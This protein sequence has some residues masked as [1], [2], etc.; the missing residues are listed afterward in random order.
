VP[1]SARLIVCGWDEVFILDPDRPQKGK[2]WSWRAADRPELPAQAAALFATTDECKPVSRGRL[3]IASSG[4]AVALVRRSTGEVLWW[5]ALPN[6]HSAEMLPGGRIVAA[7]STATHGGNRFVLYDPAFGQRELDSAPAVAAHG[8]VWD[9]ERQTLWGLCF[10]ELHA[11]GL[12]DWKGAAP[13]LSIRAAIDLPDD[14]GHDLA[15]MPGSSFLALSTRG[16]CWVFDRD[17]LRF[18]A[19]P[20]LADVPHVK[21]MDVHPQ[22][23]RLA[24]VHAEGRHWWAHHLRLRHPD[25]VLPLP[26]ERIYKARW[27]RTITRATRKR[28]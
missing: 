23:G 11:Y 8:L 17:S 3:L 4:G 7:A 28:A 19:H 2:L 6:A 5:A 16:G 21:S 1:R 26:D 12:L 10:G 18:T 22:S 20:D 25:A 13:A 24:Y 14:N 9:E 15:A 27:L